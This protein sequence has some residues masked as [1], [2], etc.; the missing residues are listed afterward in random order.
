M[1]DVKLHELE[2]KDLKGGT[3]IVS[4]PNQGIGN[5]LLTE[6]MLEQKEMATMAAFDS[7]MFPPVTMVHGGRP[8]YAIRIH[9]SEMDGLAVL[10]CEFPLEPNLAR[11]LASAIMKWCDDNG[12][13]RVIT[14]DGVSVMGAIDKDGSPDLLFAAS[15]PKTRKEGLEK[16]LDQFEEGA[17]GGVPGVLLAEGRRKGLDVVALMAVLSGPEDEVKGARVLGEHLSAFVDVDLDMDALDKKLDE[18][19]RSI[20]ELQKEMKSA[21]HKMSKDEGEGSQAPS[22]FR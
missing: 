2:D 6:F 18:A 16:D 10:R 12:I 9:G 21:M 5:V 7:D 3:L 8:R 15:D 20:E 14:L 1:I 22:M 11:P 4:I 17:L 13:K 19:K